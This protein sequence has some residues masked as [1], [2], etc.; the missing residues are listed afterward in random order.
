M[1]SSVLQQIGVLPAISQSVPIISPYSKPISRSGDFLKNAQFTE[2][3]TEV[4]MTISQ[5]PKGQ[6]VKHETKPHF[7]KSSNFPLKEPLDLPPVTSSHFQRL[8]GS[9]HMSLCFFLSSQI[10]QQWQPLP[11]GVS[12]LRMMSGLIQS[13]L[14]SQPVQLPKRQKLTAFFRCLD[15]LFSRHICWEL[16]DS[17]PAWEYSQTYVNEHGPGQRSPL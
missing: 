1:N 11:C 10:L 17:T 16:W 3:M 2:I 8:I 14:T 4:G 6:S 9:L 13:M 12:S 5:T 15:A 7:W